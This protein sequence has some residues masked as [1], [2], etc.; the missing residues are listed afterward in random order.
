MYFTKKNKNKNFVKIF[1]S[2]EIHLIDDLKTNIFIKNKILNLKKFDIFL[3]TSSIYI[4][5]CDV[6]I[7]IFV[8]NR[9]TARSPSIYSTKSMIILFRSK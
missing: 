9:S 8:K 7:S 2:R 5:N 6:I 4:K 3:L 1:I